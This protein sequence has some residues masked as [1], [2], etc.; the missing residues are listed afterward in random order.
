MQLKCQDTLNISISVAF[1]H[2]I[3]YYCNA[4]MCVCVCSQA[5]E[6]ANLLRR[7]RQY[8]ELE[9]RRF[10]RRILIARHNVEQDLAREVWKH[11]QTRTQ[12]HQPGRIIHFDYFSPPP[13]LCAVSSLFPGAEQAA[14]TEG[15]GAR[16]AA[17]APRVHAGAGVQAPGDHPEGQG[18]ADPHSAPDGAHQPAGV[19]QEE[20]E[21]AEAQARHGGPTAA[22]EPQGAGSRRGSVCGCCGAPGPK[23]HTEHFLFVSFHSQRSFRSRSSSRRPAKPRP[24]STRPSGT[25]CWR[26]RPRRTTRRC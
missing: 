13:S 23:E 16:H 11:A 3:L 24:G 5:E 9:C 22:Q 2:E 12:Q 10:K 21:G 15:P 17:Q 26:P 20:G 18:R 19:Q 1:K 4:M 7:Q 6:E 8:L 14:D 25:I